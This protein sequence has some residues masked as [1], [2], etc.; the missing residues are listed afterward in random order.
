MVGEGC[1]D[2][3]PCPGAMTFFS[4]ASSTLS[5]FELPATNAVE[6]TFPS[7][8]PW[9]NPGHTESPFGQWKSSLDGVVEPTTVPPII[10]PLSEPVSCSGKNGGVVVPV[11][12]IPF[13]VPV[14]ATKFLGR[15]GT[16]GVHS[17]LIPVHLS[18][19]LRAMLVSVT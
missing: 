15:T 9:P 1:A 8:G 13:T 11:I 5:V 4:S 7:G 6:V 2:V 16:S 19:H 17:V 18:T 10:N 14:N 3:V 12:F